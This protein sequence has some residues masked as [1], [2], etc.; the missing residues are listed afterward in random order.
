MV[1]V[2]QPVYLLVTAR[3]ALSSR[4]NCS[5]LSHALSLGFLTT[6]HSTSEPAMERESL[7][8]GRAQSS[9]KDIYLIE[10]S[11]SMIISL[12]TYSESTDLGLQLL[13]SIQSLPLCHILLAKG[14]SLVSPKLKGRGDYIG[15][16]H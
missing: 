4:G 3:A 1:E 14:R 10:S 7:T 9:V 11:P 2:I 16:E 12:L 6:W 13:P 8:K 15:C 5:C